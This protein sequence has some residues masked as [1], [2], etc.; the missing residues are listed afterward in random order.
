MTRIIRLALVSLAAWLPAAPS[1]LA[2]RPYIGYAY[3][4]GGQQGT[5][6]AV[7]LGGQT[8]T[9]VSEAVVSGAGVTARVIE[10]WPRLGPQEMQLLNEQAAELRKATSAVASAKAPA[11]MM[12]SDDSMM[13]MSSGAGGGKTGGIN[14]SL[15]NL[16]AKIDTRR[17]EYVQ[18]PACASIS[19]LVFLEVKIAPNAEPGER[20]LRVITPRGVSNPLAFHVGQLPETTRKPMT[21]ASLQVLGKEEQALRKRPTNEVEVRI[22]LPC[23]MN[24]QVASGEINRYRFA[25]RKGQ[26]L[27]VSTLARQLIPYVADAVPGWFQPVL[28]LYD[29]KGKELIYNDDFKFKPD[30]VIAYEVPKDGEYVLAIFD[31]IHRGREDFIYRISIGELPFITSLFPMGGQAGSAMSPQMRGWNLHDAH[32]KPPSKQAAPGIYQITAVR[33][34][35]HSNPMPFAVDNLP[36]ILDK[37]PNNVL[38][39]PQQVTLPVIV[40]GR[41]DKPADWDVFQFKGKPNTW[42]V[43]E[44]QARRL[45]S[46]LDSVIKLTDAAGKV[47]AF[48]DDCEDL[49][50][51]A[52]THHADSYF[53]VKLP[54]DGYYFAHIGDTARQGGPEHAYRLR[55]SAPQHD[56]A[57]RAVPSSLSL[58]S[59]STATVGIHAIRKDGYTGPIKIE[60][61]DPPPGFS[62]AP[63]T[64]AANQI[65]TRLTVKSDLRSTPEPVKLTIVGSAKIGE[66]EIVREAVP[67]EDR[68]QAFL[69]RHLLP[70]RDLL[71]LVYDPGYQPPPKRIAKPR[72]PAETNLLVSAK[73]TV[74]SNSL[75]AAALAAATNASGTNAAPP[76]PKFTKSQVASRLRQLKLLFEEGLLTDDFYH[77]K[78]AECEAA[79]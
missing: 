11:M 3:P 2:Q 59:N 72:P 17:R 25:A 9:D 56:F 54:A 65:I 50:A 76:K 5:T 34:G 49:G 21:T 66:K 64:L 74:A 24:G 57:L 27:V 75:A 30:P 79:Q 7:R 51:G 31:S 13:M 20:E 58:R 23:T 38:S 70:A 1:A 14:P 35:Q 19:S 28:A 4:A 78:V 37:E 32:L 63:V 36:E 44:V 26:R 42:V 29:D 16:L 53:M 41:I 52:N 60:L 77:E 22:S 6:F 18:T 48:N 55:I 45:D 46:P 39:A 73:T 69:W 15:T 62:A 8:L 61:K 12:M 10:Y 67:A 47:L 68:M 43:V 33:K 71:A 40:N